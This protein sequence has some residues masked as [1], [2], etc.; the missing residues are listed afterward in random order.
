MSHHF[1]ELGLEDDGKPFICAMDLLGCP[2]ST[3][4]FVVCGTCSE[5]LYGV[6]E[7][8]FEPGKEQF[9]GSRRSWWG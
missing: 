8:L 1:F 2:V 7:A 5:N 6:C 9:W 3:N 4:D